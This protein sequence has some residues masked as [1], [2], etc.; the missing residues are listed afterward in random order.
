MLLVDNLLVSEEIFETQFVCNLSKCKGECCIA[1]DS[2]APVKRE[3]IAQLEDEFQNYRPYL[4]ENGIN[5]IEKLG[6]TSY[7]TEDKV[8]KTM[9][10]EEGP[11]AFINYDK[12]GVAIC[13]IEKAYLDGKTSF[14][15]PIS[16]HLY[17]IRES[18]VGELTAVNYEEWDICADACTLGKELKVPVYKF[19]KEPLTRAY[20]EEVYDTLDSYFNQNFTSK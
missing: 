5:R 15:K 3:E 7:D 4:T 2:G 8:H 14:R 10:L 18:G 9:L 16:C 19:L 12:K 17:P 11:C 20:G 6:F 13:G 1:G